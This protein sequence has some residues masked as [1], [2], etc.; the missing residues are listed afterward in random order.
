MSSLH[1]AL[2][3]WTVLANRSVQEGTGR[4][5]EFGHYYYCV[6]WLFYDACLLGQRQ[7]TRAL[8][9]FFSSPKNLLTG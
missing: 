6:I 3:T 2:E 1:S 7:E 8:L 4:K 9:F 5:V